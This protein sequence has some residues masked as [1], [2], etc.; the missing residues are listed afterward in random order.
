MCAI[1]WNLFRFLNSIMEPFTQVPKI[2]SADII[3][4]GDPRVSL[5]IHQPRA[6]EVALQVP[7]IRF[8]FD[9]RAVFCADYDADVDATLQLER[10]ASHAH[11]HVHPRPLSRPRPL[12]TPIRISIPG[13]SATPPPVPLPFMRAHYAIYRG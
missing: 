12:A 11:S 1:G 4:A 7:L 6:P 8:R 10:S 5:G 2:S 3:Y 13:A 9:C